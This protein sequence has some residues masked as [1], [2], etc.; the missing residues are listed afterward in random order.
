MP[1]NGN[2]NG[3]WDRGEKG[4]LCTLKMEFPNT[5]NV[6]FSVPI[7]TGRSSTAQWKWSPPAPGSLKT[8]SVSIPIERSTKQGNARG[9]SEVRRGTSSIHFH[10]PVPRSSSPC[11]A[12][13]FWIFFSQAVF[14]GEGKWGRTK[15]Y[16]RIPRVRVTGR[17]ESQS[18]PSPERLFKTKDLELP[19]FEGS[20][21]SCS[22]HSA[23]YTRTSLHPY[24]PRCPSSWVF[25]LLFFLSARIA[26]LPTL[27]RAQNQE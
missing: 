25:F 21:P 26:T 6:H 7:L 16:R 4:H 15:K 12:W 9:T 5:K 18:F 24:F 14:L 10:C 8:P 20:L 17:D 11:E 1:E 22:P 13:S 3:S 19:F 2:L 27:Y 23:G